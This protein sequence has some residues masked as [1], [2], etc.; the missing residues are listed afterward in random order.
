MSLALTATLI[1]LRCD[2]AAYAGVALAAV[3]IPGGTQISTN[4]SS[5]EL[6]AVIAA[7][8]AAVNCTAQRLLAIGVANVAAAAATD[9]AAAHRSLQQTTTVPYANVDVSI[10][11][12]M[13]AVGAFAVAASV[14]SAPIPAFP[15]TTAA[16]APLWSYSVTGWQTAV[17]FPFDI[18]VGSI[19]TSNS[20][21]YSPKPTP[22]LGSE[23]LALGLSIG[24]GL[25]LLLAF[26]GLAWYRCRSTA[27][28]PSERRIG[29][30]FIT[31]RQRS[32]G[33]LDIALALSDLDGKSFGAEL[34]GDRLVVR[35]LTSAGFARVVELQLFAPLAEGGAIASIVLP[36]AVLMMGLHKLA[37]ADRSDAAGAVAWPRLLRDAEADDVL[38]GVGDAPF[39]GPSAGARAMS[40]NQS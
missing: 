9:A 20:V 40:Q 37:A 23:P 2:Y 18:N 33:V 4:F 15:R 38:A 36:H 28:A 19:T 10:I 17:G 32:G 3:R 1:G 29:V 8:N 16:W 27:A 11:V 34:A 22:A 12:T 30:K 31:Y 25:C 24:I 5:A 7:A 35:W 26:A 21:T 6:I 14:A 13:S 39:D